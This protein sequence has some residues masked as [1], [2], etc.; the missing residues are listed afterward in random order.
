MNVGCISFRVSKFS[1]DSPMSLRDRDSRRLNSF[2][3]YLNSK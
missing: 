1:K 2:S 3:D